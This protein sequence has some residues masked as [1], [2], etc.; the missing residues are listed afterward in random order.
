MFLLFI[1][2]CIVGIAAIEDS[3]DAGKP[4]DNIIMGIILLVLSFF[5]FST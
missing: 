4:M 3:N 1:G 5:T 2:L